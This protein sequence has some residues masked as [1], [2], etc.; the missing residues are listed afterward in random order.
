VHRLIVSCIILGLQILLNIGYAKDLVF[1]L[2]VK[3]AI[4]PATSDYVSR[5]IVKA[6][7]ERA[8]LLIINLDTPGGLDKSMRDIIK[9]I[10]ASSIPI[11]TYISP[12]GARAASAGTFILYASHI[13]CM[14]PG[15]NIGAASPVSIGGGFPSLPDGKSKDKK[16]SDQSVLKSKVTN[17][18][19]AYIRSIAQM[20]KRNVKWAEQA[21]RIAA[22]LTAKD[23]LKKNVI[24]FI[25]NDHKELISN[26]QGKK[27][28]VLG[29][30]VI[31]KIEDPIIKFMEPDWRSKFLSV[32]TDPSV[33][34]I[35]LLIGMYGLFFE[36]ANPGFVVP[37]VIGGIALIIALYALQLLPISYA[38]LGLLILGVGFMIAEVFMPSFGI[39]GIGGTIA[40]VIG[41]I[42]LFDT[43]LA[44]FQIAY[45]IIVAMVILNILFFIFI[46]G[47]AIKARRKRV[48]SGREG[49]ID[50]IGIAL[51]DI[52]DTGM[53]RVKGEMWQIQTSKPL[54]KDQKFIVQRVDG[55][56]LKVK[57][58][59][60]EGLIKKGE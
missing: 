15:T 55:L 13:A 54:K 43:E 48:I 58:T 60:N 23:A 42:L 34:Y 50:S 36:F 53:A 25:A 28:I 41:S 39:L 1:S 9:S 4:G 10:F 31:I 45:P 27:V 5:S 8:K 2:D 35:I 18:A 46:L 17:D 44:A 26:I 32:I 51:E 37:G 57:P 24:D 14:A 59:E 16:P 6:G 33:A 47:A 7:N 20:R 38:G 29:K 56:L 30:D 21:V 40:F 22:T 3:G 12:S 49:L 19:I 11:A 52:S